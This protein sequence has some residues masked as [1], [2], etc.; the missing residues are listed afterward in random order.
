MSAATLSVRQ[1]RGRTAICQLLR[2]AL[3]GGKVVAQPSG[4]QQRTLI[5]AREL[6]YVDSDNYLTPSG[7]SRAEAARRA[8]Q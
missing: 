6:G 3:H 5:R 8:V 2:A 7:R 1:V 4:K